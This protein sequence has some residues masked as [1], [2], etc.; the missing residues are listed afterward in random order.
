MLS[1]P[2]RRF[3]GSDGALSSNVSA[4][5]E[6]EEAARA[7]AGPLQAMVGAPGLISRLFW[8]QNEPKI[9]TS[10]RGVSGQL[11]AKILYANANSRHELSSP[12][13]GSKKAA[14]C[15]E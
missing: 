15:A 14:L 3:S 9:E 11:W 6:P 10:L 2:L 4:P 5:S 13:F 1:G 8:A 7:L 12:S